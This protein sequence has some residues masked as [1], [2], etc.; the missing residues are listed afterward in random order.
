M[1]I[2]PQRLQFRNCSAAILGPKSIAA[3]VRPADERPT[4]SGVPR[5]ARISRMLDLIGFK[6]HGEW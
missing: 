3:A 2:A 5:S 1:Q 6:P 4:Y